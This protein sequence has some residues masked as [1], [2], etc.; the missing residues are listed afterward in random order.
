MVLENIVIAGERSVR[1]GVMEQNALSDSE[2]VTENRL[3][4]FR[5]G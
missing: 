5:G 1:G 3:R 4:K 2:H